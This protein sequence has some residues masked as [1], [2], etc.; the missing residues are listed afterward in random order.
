MKELGYHKGYRYDHDWPDA[1]SG[2]DFFP[3]EF[4]GDRRPEF[5]QPNERGFEREVIKRLEFWANRRE[6][7]RREEGE[8]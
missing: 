5:Y 8:G 7:R 2:Q 3:D 6:A 1:H 4:A